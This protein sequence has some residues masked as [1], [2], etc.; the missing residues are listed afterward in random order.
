MT[1]Q[2]KEELVAWETVHE[3]DRGS[4]RLTVSCQVQQ[5]CA[6]TTKKFRLPWRTFKSMVPDEH[7]FEEGGARDIHHCFKR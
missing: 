7:R 5:L 6:G 1:V 4:E 3:Y 2:F